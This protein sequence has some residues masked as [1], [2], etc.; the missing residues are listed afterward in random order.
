MVVYNAAYNT[1]QMFWLCVVGCNIH[2][3]DRYYYRMNIF[4]AFLKNWKDKLIKYFFTLVQVCISLFIKNL[5]VVA[6][7]SIKYRM[8]LFFV[9]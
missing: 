8:E 4:K 9:K 2:D 1:K 5:K 3:F 7:W 6:Q